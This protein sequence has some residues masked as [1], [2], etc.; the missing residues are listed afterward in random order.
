M[1]DEIYTIALHP[2]GNYLVASFNSSIQFLNIYPKRIEKYHEIP[3]GSGGICNDIKFT[4]HGNLVA[5]QMGG[6]VHVYRFF[7]A[8]CPDN[9]IFKGHEGHLRNISWTDDDSGL[10]TTGIDNK[11]AVWHLPKP[12]ALDKRP[13]PIWS[14]VS[15]LNEFIST[16]S[17][18]VELEASER[19]SKDNKTG[20]KQVVFGMGKKDVSI[21]EI[22]QDTREGGDKTQ[23][24]LKHRYEVGTPFESMLLYTSRSCFFGG[25]NGEGRPGSVMIVPFPFREEKPFEVQVHSAGVS[26]MC[27]NFEHTHLFTASADGS[28]AFL[29][30]TDKTGRRGP[31]P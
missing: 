28:F 25:V 12:E 10:I 20:T 14:Y 19:N 6:E 22:L 24:L 13:E 16:V 8:T 1:H 26:R 2:S 31:M 3:K 30:I 29:Q 11:I 27:L 17:I 9:Y 15:K 23:G 21:H 7:T 5:I 18:K 4:T